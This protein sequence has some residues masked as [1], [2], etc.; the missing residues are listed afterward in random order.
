MRFFIS[1]EIMRATAAKSEQQQTTKTHEKRRQHHKQPKQQKAEI[2]G[3]TVADMTPK[4]QKQQ[5]QQQKQ[6][7]EQIFKPNMVTQFFNEQFTKSILNTTKEEGGIN[8]VFKNVMKST[9]KE[10]VNVINITDYAGIDEL[11]KRVEE[12]RKIMQQPPDEKQE[13]EKET[14]KTIVDRILNFELRGCLDF[15]LNYDLRDKDNLAE[16]LEIMMQ[17]VRLPQ[18]KKQTPRDLFALLDVYFEKMLYHVKILNTVFPQKTE[19][20]ERRNMFRNRGFYLHQIPKNVNSVFKL[21]LEG[22]PV[23]EI[24]AKIHKIYLNEITDR[25]LRKILSAKEL[26]TIE[27]IKEIDYDHFIPENIDDNKERRRIRME[28]NICAKELI[29]VSKFV[30]IVENCRKS[31][32]IDVT[33]MAEFVEEYHRLMSDFAKLY[34][35]RKTLPEDGYTFENFIKYFMDAFSLYCSAFGS[36]TNRGGLFKQFMNIIDRKR[37]IEFSPEFKKEIST[38]ENTKSEI[39]SNE[40]TTLE[41]QERFNCKKLTNFLTRLGKMCLN[42][43]NK[44]RLPRGIYMGLAICVLRHIQDQIKQI[45]LTQLRRKEIRIYLDK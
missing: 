28:I 35:K 11:K 7:K 20:G 8:V 19:D 2:L 3:D 45:M 15:T 40:F 25:D 37:V 36:S 13:H 14:I 10:R 1:S 42:F 9:N 23:E 26:L 29:N 16:L 41:Q 12:S 39:I 34:A 33:E 4:P 43:Q 30:E 38:T 21:Y 44:E 18:Y 27:K 22:K 24:R 31:K 32:G 6:P 5:K 17:N